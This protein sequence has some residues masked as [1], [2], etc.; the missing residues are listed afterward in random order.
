MAVLNLD[1]YCG[2]DRYSDGDVE[3]YILEL[4]K[5]GKTYSDAAADENFFPVYYHLSP[6]RENILNW[7]PLKKTDDILEIGAGCGAITGVLCRNGGA[8]T[9]VELSKRRSEINHIRNGQYRNLEI[10]AG[11][12][13]DVKLEKKYDY[14]ILNG[15]F[16]YAMGFTEGDDPYAAFLMQVKQ[17][18][19]PNGKILIAIE[20]RLGLKYF[21]GAAEDHTGRYYDGLNGYAGNDSVRTFSKAELLGIFRRCGIS[22]WKFYYPYPDYKFPTEI[23]TDENVNGSGFGR[24]YINYQGSRVKLFDEL[25][26]IDAFKAE[27]AMGS[28]ANSFLVEL[29]V[30]DEADCC[31]IIYAK[32]NNYRRKKFCIA[33]IISKSHNDYCVRKIPLNELAESHIKKI[34]ENQFKMNGHKLICLESRLV[35]GGI[36]SPYIQ[37]ENMDEEF[38]EYI[39]QKD[40]VGIEKRLMHIYEALSEKSEYRENI[41][42]GQFRECFGNAQLNASVPCIQMANIDLILDNLFWKDGK[43]IAID[44]EWVL[45]FWV[46][47]QFIMWRLLNDWYSRYEFTE[48]VLKKEELFAIFGITYEMEQC[49]TE[50]AVYFLV[51]YVS[52]HIDQS[53]YAVFTRKIDI[54]SIIRE[55]NA[56]GMAY[57]DKLRGA[58]YFDR[59]NG[60]SADDLRHVYALSMGNGRYRCMLDISDLE[61]VISVRYDPLEGQSCIVTKCNIMQGNEKLEASYS[62]G[63][64]GNTGAFLIG[65]DPMIL[66]QVKNN[67]DSI[68]LET[69]FIIEGGMFIEETLCDFQAM[70]K[71]YLT[72]CQ[73]AESLEGQVG[74]LTAQNVNFRG[75]IEKLTAQNGGLRAEI[76]SLTARSEGLY[77]EMGSLATRNDDLCAEI[78]GLITR[79]DDLCAEVDSLATQNDGLREEIKSL[80]IQC[81]KLNDDL[82]NSGRQNLGLI[83]D[84]NAYIILANKKDELLI[85]KDRIINDLEQNNATMEQKA[86]YYKNRTC[87]KTCDRFWKIYWKIRLGLRKMVGKKDY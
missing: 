55:Q 37:S 39:R 40:N 17:C 16:E 32:L 1:Y 74:I 14:A 35:N 7:Y 77:A 13:S 69:E 25:K 85:K 31:D 34:Y 59:K 24:P 56:A 42:D 28:F 81:Q 45:D 46:P 18:L 63:F 76:E 66:A 30:S 47:V 84:L 50:W 65:P 60:F 73:K 54:D 48:D 4:V 12:L 26:M 82:D 53:D 68:S 44:L 67:E 61:N 70:Q 86:D 29:C 57:P 78:D 33:T 19:K 38:R 71:E 80:K 83:Q 64:F 21:S 79:K 11:S 43:I 87:I 75:E 58:I 20:N 9:S 10:M 49:F 22:R 36:E 8:V 3:N 51:H 6:E 62:V 15:V 23:F 27:K 52:Q 2:E 5:N 41:Y 72:C